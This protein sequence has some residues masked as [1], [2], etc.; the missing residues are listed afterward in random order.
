MSPVAITFKTAQSAVR[1]LST[2]IESCQYSTP[3][4]HQLDQNSYVMAA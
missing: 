4:I 3:T 1:Q 2:V